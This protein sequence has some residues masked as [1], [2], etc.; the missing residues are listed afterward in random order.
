MDKRQ[1]YLQALA[2]IN[3]L[4][5]FGIHLGLERITELLKRLGE[6]QKKIKVIH[7]GGTNGK[8]STA[9]ILQALLMAHGYQV[10]LFSSPH[11]H[12]YRERIRINERYIG[13][14]ELVACLERIKNAIKGML[15]EGF[16]QPTEFE[17]ST[18]LALVYFAH[19]KPDFVIM[20]VGLGGE[21]DSTNVV[22]P[23]V[24][25]LTP[26]GI[27]HKDYLGA[28]VAEIAGVKA[29]IIKGGAP[30]VTAVQKPEA[31][32]II[33]KK[34]AARASRLIRAAEDFNWRTQKKPDSFSYQGLRLSFNS[35]ELSLLGEHQFA[36]AASA[37]A[38]CEVLIDLGSLGELKEVAVR[39]ALKRVTWPARLELILNKPKVLLDG[40]HNVEGMKSLIRALDYY[41]GSILQRKR[42]ILCLGM[43]ADKEV[44]ESAAL[45]LP[46]ADELLV[47]RPDTDRAGNWQDL[48]CIAE[49]YLPKSKIRVLPQPLKALEEGLKKTG[50]QDLLCI[51]GSLYLL[52][53][54]REHLLELKVK[55]KLI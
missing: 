38:V 25:V 39:S 34:A 28:S 36:N 45:I 22:N 17:V 44:E 26:I 18:A 52:A 31:R 35:L 3:K 7:I 9:V 54:I 11:L 20:E 29:G 2:Y 50:P 14:E 40:A 42:L 47:T 10:G 43:L 41:S 1:E 51:T 46:L 53:P 33:E 5:K 32:R 6:P 13:E 24:V 55:N 37:L 12:D 48:A 19:Q 30:V 21:I 27:D 49:N 4:T 15:E 8:G 16:E 23:L